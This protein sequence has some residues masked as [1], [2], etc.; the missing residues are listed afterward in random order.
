LRRFKAGFDSPIEGLVG[1]LAVGE[2]AGQP[3]RPHHHGEEPDGSAASG[4]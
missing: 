2:S 1:E 4:L 3:Q